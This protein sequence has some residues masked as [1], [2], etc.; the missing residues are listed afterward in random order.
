M[1]PQPHAHL[2]PLVE[3][4]LGGDGAGDALLLAHRPVLLEGAG[5]LDGRLV[6]ARAAEDLVVALGRAK[7]TLRRPRLVGGQLRVRD[8]SEVQRV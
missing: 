6:D 1:V 3:M 7:A 4:G 8:N 2:G 5:A